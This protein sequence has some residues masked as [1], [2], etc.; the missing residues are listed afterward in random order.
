MSSHEASSG[1]TY[2]SISSDYKEPSNAGS[3]GVIVYGYDGLP[4][5]PVD[6]YEEAAYLSP[7]NITDSDP[8]DGSKNGTTD[9][10]ADG[11]DDDDDDDS[12]RDD[13]DVED[14]EEVSKEEDNH[15]ALADSTAVPPTIDLVLSAKVP[16]PVE[17]D[18]SAAA[19]PPPPAYH[20]TSRMHVRSQG[21]IPFPSEAEVDRLL[22][23]PTPPPSPLTPLSSPLP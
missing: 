12:S 17:T 13:A 15:L 16:E 21:S 6:P 7:S 20:T 1:V 3:L 5:H 11:G 19:P 18:E 2:T 22:A 8:E 14:K 10:P 9:Y 4:M 23:L